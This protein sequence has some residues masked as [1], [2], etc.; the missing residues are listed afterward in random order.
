MLIFRHWKKSSEAARK[1][2]LLTGMNT[3]L[4][5]GISTRLLAVGLQHETQWEK[6]IFVSQKMPTA[7][8]A[9]D[10][11]GIDFPSQKTEVLLKTRS[12]AHF[13]RFYCWNFGKFM[14]NGNGAD[15]CNSERRK[16]VSGC[17]S[18]HSCTEWE[19]NS[20]GPIEKQCIQ[21]KEQWRLLHQG[22]IGGWELNPGLLRW[23]TK[24]Q[25]SK[26]K[27]QK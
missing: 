27:T 22:R 18:G 14:P 19:Q 10:K 12:Q 26:G 6:L 8:A 21:Q 20:T 3:G 16:L 2:A 24:M 17:F 15:P 7:K 23:A 13:P 9:H 1:W 25:L 5:S 11:L 4:I